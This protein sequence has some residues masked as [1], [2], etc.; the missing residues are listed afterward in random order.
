MSEH[1]LADNIENYLSRE[2]NASDLL[3]AD[4]H[5]AQCDLCFARLGEFRRG[6]KS[7]N[8]DFLQFSPEESEH[9]SY[10]RLEA[11][12]DEKTDGVEREIAD[13]HLQ[14]CA[15]CNLQLDGLLQMRRLIETDA[16][17][18]SILRQPRA[19]SVF[20]G[21][22][23]F[24]SG[25]YSL[26]YG[27]GT[28][29]AV[30]LIASLF[31]I[32]VLRRSDAPNE[33]AATS[34]PGVKPQQN[35]QSANI[36]SAPDV[37]TNT[38]VSANANVRKQINAEIN[39]VNRQTED[40]VPKNLSPK[41]EA[42]VARVVAS[43]RLNFPPELKTL[44]NQVGKLMG[45]ETE[46]IPFALTNPIGKIVQTNR[47]QFRW[48][49]LAGAINY[50]VSVYDTDFN[51]VATSPQ[52]S[53]TNWQIGEP[54][55]RGKTYVWQV[56]AIKNG[57]EIKSPARPAPDARFKI[58]DRKRADELARLSRQYKNEHLFLGI[59]YANEGLLDEAEREFQKETE[60]NPKSKTAQKFLREVREKRK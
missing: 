5:L 58:L 28:L 49:E 39:G 12:V 48:R 36:A 43:E 32:F 7:L 42:E 37:Q 15:D 1:L 27:F 19:K 8:L 9:L 41:P 57:E 10:E 47:P 51:R 11:Y 14:V 4:E 20:G 29:A 60:K 33:I 3:K 52:I 25:N 40:A 23:E 16:E 21:I 17:K 34:A 46:G 6:E 59:A 56:T 45:G 35:V 44:N 22:R 38:E 54:L 50:V 13:V 24:L 53:G 55:A 26:K 30:L 2:M 18:Q 31:G